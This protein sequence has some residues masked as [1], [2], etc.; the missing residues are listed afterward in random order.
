MLARNSM[1]MGLCSPHRWSEAD[2]ERYLVVIGLLSVRTILAETITRVLTCLA[3]IMYNKWRNRTPLI[4]SRGAVLHSL[5]LPGTLRPPSCTFPL[6]PER[7]H[8]ST[9][10]IL[11]RD[12][13]HTRFR[14]ITPTST[15]DLVLVR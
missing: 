11:G 5:I 9:E 15:G 7:H 14:I 4:K 1:T 6:L 8:N 3:D 13:A 12:Q 2:E 10:M